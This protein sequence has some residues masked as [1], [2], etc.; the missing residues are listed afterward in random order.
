MRCANC[1]Q[2]CAMLTLD[3]VLSFIDRY[4]DSDESNEVREVYTSA[5]AWTHEH[6]CYANIEYEP[7]YPGAPRLREA[8]YRD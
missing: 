1:S 8:G 2:C 6:G 7:R 3:S 4:A 5:S